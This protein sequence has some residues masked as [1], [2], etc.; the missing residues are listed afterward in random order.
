MDREK[1]QQA[2]AEIT[3]L[4]FKSKFAPVNKRFNDWVFETYS[5]NIVHISTGKFILGIF[6]TRMSGELMC[7]DIEKKSKWCS[8][9]KLSRTNQLDDRL[10]YNQVENIFIPESLAT[11]VHGI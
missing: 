6:L 10:S 2:I 5:K 9:R 1:K 4:K 3:W 8:L 7:L 11:E